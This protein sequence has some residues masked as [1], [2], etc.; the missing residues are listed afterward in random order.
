MISYLV[1]TR[2]ISIHIQMLVLW[3]DSQ[4]KAAFLEKA[5][6]TSSHKELASGAA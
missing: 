5:L 6:T 2:W 3:M 4:S 1:S